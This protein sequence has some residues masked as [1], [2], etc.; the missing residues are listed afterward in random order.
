RSPTWPGSGASLLPDIRVVQ[1]PRRQR[2]AAARGHGRASKPFVERLVPAPPS[3]RAS[4]PSSGSTLVALWHGRGR[5]RG[6]SPPLPEQ[7]ERSAGAQPASQRIRHGEVSLI[8]DRWLA[9]ERIEGAAWR[10]TGLRGRSTECAR[11]DALLE[12]I[13]RGESRSL[14]LRGEAGIGK[15]A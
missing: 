7:A 10:L 12:A 14:L 8:Y 6:P 5:S 1:R 13:R 2:V 3:G 4:S 9:M 15:T 11:L